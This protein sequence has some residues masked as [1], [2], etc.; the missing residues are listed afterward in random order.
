MS[1]VILITGLFLSVISLKRLKN[2][3][4][5]SEVKTI[6]PL[7]AWTAFC[8][9]AGLFLG[10]KSIHISITSF[11]VISG[12]LILTIPLQAW[13]DIKYFYKDKIWSFK[14]FLIGCSYEIGLVI[15]GAAL[16][17]LYFN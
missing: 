9:G 17:R 6:L 16:V 4:R 15:A 12:A 13:I 10:Y 14:D 2:K 7:P 11:V 8:F 3:I 1:V 5:E